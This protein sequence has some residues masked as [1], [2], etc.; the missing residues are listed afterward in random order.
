MK[1]VAAHV[2]AIWCAAMASAL[3]VLMLNLVGMG[4]GPLLVGLLNDALAP[5]LGVEAVRYSLMFAVVPHALAAIFN[6]LA[7]RHLI[8]DLAVA[9][10]EAVSPA[11][12]AR[13]STR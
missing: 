3:I 8:A 7:A 4:L 13:P 10:G 12:S 11:A 2:I 9:R 6:L 5:S 1:V